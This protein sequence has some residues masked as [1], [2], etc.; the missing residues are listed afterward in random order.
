MQFCAVV[1]PLKHPIAAVDFTPSESGAGGD[2]TSITS[3][4]DNI[5][6]ANNHFKPVR[7]TAVNIPTDSEE[8]SPSLGRR[9][10]RRPHF[11][12]RRSLGADE[13]ERWS[14]RVNSAAVSLVTAPVCSTHSST[15]ICTDTRTDTTT[16]TTPSM[17][18][19]TSSLL[20]TAT[21]PTPIMTVY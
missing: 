4:A 5:N 20:D 17:A 16:A 14:R 15:T 12:R 21:A 13:R 3:F 1:F 9:Q 19:R 10:Q 6:A 2:N 7:T 11:R 18:P 8:S